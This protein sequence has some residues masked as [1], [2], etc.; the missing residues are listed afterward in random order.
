MISGLEGT[1]EGWIQ[2]KEVMKKKFEN[3]I[4]DTLMSAAF[5]SYAGPFPAH[6]RRDFI[7]NLLGMVRAM[8]IQHSRDY[9]F[10]DF[11]VK[12]IDFLNWNFQGLPDD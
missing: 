1:K 8:K 2:R 10:A 4:G 3:L 12:Q 6:Y 5:M 9:K 7:D 11:L